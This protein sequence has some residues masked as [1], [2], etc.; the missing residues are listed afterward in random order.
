MNYDSWYRS[1]HGV[2]ISSERTAPGR[3]PPA[4]T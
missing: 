4:S 2:M 3:T 1:R